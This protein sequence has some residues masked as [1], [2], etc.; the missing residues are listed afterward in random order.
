MGKD[1]IGHMT[2]ATP[3]ILARLSGRGLSDYTGGEAYNRCS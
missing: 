2:A 3:K 1:A